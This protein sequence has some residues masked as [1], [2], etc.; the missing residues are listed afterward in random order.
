[1][2]YSLGALSDNC[3][4]GGAVL[5]NKYDIRDEQQLSDVETLIVSSKA[6]QFELS[7]FPG[8][9]DFEYYKS[10]HRFLFG[11]LYDWA[12]QVRTIDLSKQGTKF[13]PT[14]EIEERAALVFGRLQP[15]K[16]WRGC[17]FQEYVSEV[18][19]LYCATNELHPFKEGNGRTQR[20]ILTQ[21]IRSTGYDID[22]SDI[23][24]DLL[25]VATIQAASGVT[26]LLCDIF[27]Q[28]IKQ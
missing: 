16:F 17:S 21:F 20:V 6:A 10:V 4:P 28:A 22:F 8:T 1:M 5:I 9:L 15:V 18:V 25:M 23:D 19:D 24:G 13:C 14:T 7:P 12:G 11:D 26:D 3:Y 2:A 27:G